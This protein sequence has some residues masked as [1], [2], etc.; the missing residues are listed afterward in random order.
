MQATVKPRTNKTSTTPSETST[1]L[2]PATKANQVT[3]AKSALRPKNPPSGTPIQSAR[4]AA[5]A[6]GSGLTAVKS[7]GNLKAE[8][9]VQA[10][11]NE[12]KARRERITEQRRLEDMLGQG[13]AL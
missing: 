5:R 9:E 4:A 6:R 11:R 10:R 7:R 8:L 12:I 3:P 2:N 13:Q 1:V